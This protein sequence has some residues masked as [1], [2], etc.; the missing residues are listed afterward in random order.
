MGWHH[1]GPEDAESMSV[2]H[3]RLSTC[4]LCILYASVDFLCG[5]SRRIVIRRQPLQGSPFQAPRLAAWLSDPCDGESSPS[6][7]ACGCRFYVVLYQSSSL[8]Q[9]SVSFLKSSRSRGKTSPKRAS[10]ATPMKTIKGQ[11]APISRTAMTGRRYIGSCSGYD[12]DAS[13]VTYTT[14]YF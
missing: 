13:T 10:I 7:V 4:K 9:S 2:D 12:L 11:S 5:S 8:P 14:T 1:R 3:R 6:C